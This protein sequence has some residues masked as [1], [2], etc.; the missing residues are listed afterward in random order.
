MKI[1]IQQPLKKVLPLA[2]LFFY[3]ST[4]LAGV[5]DVW[6]ASPPTNDTV[7][8]QQNARPVK[9]GWNGS[10][11]GEF[12]KSDNGYYKDP[13]TGYIHQW[14]LGRGVVTLPMTCPTK[15]ISVVSTMGESHGDYENIYANVIS[16]SQIGLYH[17]KKGANG[18]LQRYTVVCY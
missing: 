10:G 7:W 12:L 2:F 15:V 5:E 9:P 18:P 16:N 3:C 14:G 1:Y 4:V 6:N 11:Q 8:A 17:V 13:A